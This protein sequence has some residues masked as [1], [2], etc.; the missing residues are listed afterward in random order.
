M[1]GAVQASASL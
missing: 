1:P